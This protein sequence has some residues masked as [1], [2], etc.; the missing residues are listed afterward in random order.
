MQRAYYQRLAEMTP[1]ERVA[2]GVALWNAGDSMQRAA[3]RRLYPQADEDEIL[4]RLA[5]TRY[6]PELASKAY[7]RQE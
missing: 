5:V 1:A 4:F 6:G 7:G 2:I 3:L